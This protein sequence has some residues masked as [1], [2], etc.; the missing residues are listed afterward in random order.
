MFLLYKTGMR[1]IIHTANL[2]EMDWDLKTQGYFKNFVLENFLMQIFLTSIWMSELF[3]RIP[4]SKSSKPS[5][6]D[7]YDSKTKFKS[8]LITYL[9]YYK[10]DKL[11]DWI[12]HIKS[13]DMSSAK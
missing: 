13:H 6:E 1:V 9:E 12:N 8:Y 4:E 10:E 3:P 2:I 5:K 7:P 11:N